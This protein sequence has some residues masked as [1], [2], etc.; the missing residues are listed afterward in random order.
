MAQPMLCGARFRTRRREE[1]YDEEVLMDQRRTD[2]AAWDRR[3]VWIWGHRCVSSSD[4]TSG[5]PRGGS[6]GRT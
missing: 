3:W 4:L 6:T 2:E 1:P 5:G